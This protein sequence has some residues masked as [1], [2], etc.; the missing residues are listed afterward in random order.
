MTNDIT[1]T[2]SAAA[3]LVSTAT[4]Y[5][6]D[7]QEFVDYVIGVLNGTEAN[8]SRNDETLPL[9]SKIEIARTVASYPLKQLQRTL[10][11]FSGSKESTL[12]MYILRDVC[13]EQGKKL[14][15]VLFVDNFM[16]YDQTMEFVQK[17]S[18]EWNFNV[19][20]VGNDSLRDKK[21]GETVNVSDLPQ[22]QKEELSRIGFSGLQF[23]VS[24]DDNA[25]NHLLNAFVI[26]QHAAAGRY[27]GVFVSDDYLMG[28]RA[29][30]FASPSGEGWIRITPL[31][32]L[33]DREIL[34]YMQDNGIPKNPVYVKGNENI[35]NRY[36]KK[37]SE[38]EDDQAEFMG[39][40]ENLKRLGYA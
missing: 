19:K 33:S 24:S 18:G 10:V 36:E 11:L 17:L 34:S 4:H 20:T 3:R 22:N 31:L 37:V 23:L 13:K 14:P 2:G 16:H 8:L 30:S 28:R 1:I 32:L 12:T 26:N 5:G 40:V 39:V 6:F 7:P 27:E 25:A 15:D 29:R 35:F 9:D 21:Y 38:S